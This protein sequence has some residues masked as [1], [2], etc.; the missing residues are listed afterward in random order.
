M[1]PC[2]F[3]KCMFPECQ[4]RNHIDF[5]NTSILNFTSLNSTSEGCIPGLEPRG[6]PGLEPR[7][8][9][10]KAIFREQAPKFGESAF[11]IIVYGKYVF[12]KKT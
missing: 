10:N 9:R 11:G 8:W 4:F 6:F 2:L 1:A 3:P 5:T 7:G 12:E